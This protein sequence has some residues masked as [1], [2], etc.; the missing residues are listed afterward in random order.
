MV[1]PLWSV[2]LTIISITTM[3]VAG[4]KRWEGWALGLAG[5]LVWITYAL[6]TIQY[7]FVASAIL[8][9]TVYGINLRRWRNEDS[10]TERA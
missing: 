6:V 9:G 10:N 2:S 1:N 3:Y 4:R 8:H 5:Q 7:A